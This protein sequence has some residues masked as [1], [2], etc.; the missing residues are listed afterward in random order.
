MST[1]YL[2]DQFAASNPVID[3]AQ[4]DLSFVDATGVMVVK[5]PA[6]VGI[7][8]QPQ[9]LL[10]LNQLKRAGLHR[11]YAATFSIT[12]PCLTTE[13]VDTALSTKVQLAGGTSTL[14][15]NNH[16]LL[17]VGSVLATTKFGVSIASRR[18]A[19]V[20][21]AY[22]ITTLDAGRTTRRYE[23]RIP[24]GLSCTVTFEDAAPPVTITV[25]SGETQQLISSLPSTTN[26]SLKFSSAS[27]GRLFL[28]SWAVLYL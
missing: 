19:V 1:Y 26:I 24:S 5:L 21:E 6:D 28:G 20:W 17:S 11:R 2:L 8:G 12:D 16:C 10:E 13:R 25:G 7:D 4:N 23:D 27:S 22:A 3:V 15:N 14:C 18:F 9:N